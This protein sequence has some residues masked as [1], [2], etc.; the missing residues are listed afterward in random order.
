MISLAQWI[1]VHRPPVAS[2]D[3]NS[4]AT[5]KRA[6]GLSNHHAKGNT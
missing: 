6:S 2:D 3:E 4:A 5:G 1:E